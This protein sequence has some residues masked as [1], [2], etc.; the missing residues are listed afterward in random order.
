MRRKRP[1]YKLEQKEVT[2]FRI[3]P[4]L[5]V[6]IQRKYGGMQ[7]FIDKHV[8]QCIEDKIIID[9]TKEVK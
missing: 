2:S 6:Q 4:T 8:N 3:K 9:L 1:A 7:T 5:K